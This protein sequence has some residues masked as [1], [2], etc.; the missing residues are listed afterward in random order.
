MNRFLFILLVICS[1]ASGQDINH[2]SFNDLYD[3]NVTTVFDINERDDHTMW[4]GTSEGLV[5]FD[6]VEFKTFVNEDYAIAYTNIKFDEAGRVWCSNFGGQ[7]FYLE[8]DSLQLGVNWQ[9]QGDFIRDY[10]VNQLPDMQVVG[11]NTGEILVFNVTDASKSKSVFK[12]DRSKILSMSVRDEMRYA[13]FKEDKAVNQGSLDLYELGELPAENSVV[14]S[15]SINLPPGKWNIF[16]NEENLLMYHFDKVGNLYKL[17]DDTIQPILE[18]IELST[19]RLNGV[20]LI[21]DRIWVLSKKG[22]SIY[23]KDGEEYITGSFDGTSVS[24]VFKDHEGNIWLGSLNRGIYVIPN[25]EFTSTLLS[26][27][28]IAHSTFDE[29]G[30]LFVLDDE[31][32]LYYVPYGPKKYS[33]IQLITKNLEP[34]PLFYDDQAKKLFIGNLGTYFDCANKR[35]VKENGN[36]HKRMRFKE[37]VKLKND[38]YVFTNYSY[39]GLINGTEDKSQFNFDLVKDYNIRRFRSKHIGISG[40]KDH[41]YIDYI[42]GLFYYSK[43]NVPKRLKRRGAD[44]QSSRIV[45]DPINNEIVWVATKTK[46]LLKFDKGK[47]VKSIKLPDVANRISIHKD[48]IFLAGQQAIM[49]YDRKSEDIDFIDETDGWMKGRVTSMACKDSLCLI[50]GSNFL[51]KFPVYYSTVN[52]VVPE[53]YITSINEKKY[54]SIKEN[55]LIFPPGKNYIT[56][57]FRGLSVRSQKKLNYQYRLS[58]K[59]NEWIE[60]S[61]DRPEALFL[62][63]EAGSYTFEV[64]ACNESGVCSEP[65]TLQFTIEE[66]YYKKWWF[67]GVVFLT[68]GLIIFFTLRERFKTKEKQERLKS[69]QQR[70]RKEAYKSKIAAI[71]SQM[72][73]HFMFNALNTIQEFILTNQQEIASEYLADF[74]DLMRIYLDQSREDNVSISTEVETLELYLR[75]EN[76]RFNGDLTYEVKVDPLINKDGTTIPV[77]LLQP[78]VENSIKHGLLHKK[79]D[80]RLVISF[81]R[82]DN[83]GIKCVVEDNGIGRTSS[84]KINKSKSIGHKSFATGANQSRVELINQNRDKKLKVNI[85]DLYKD[86]GP[87]GTRVEIYI[88]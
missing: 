57:S 77:M 80:K 17:K 50:V 25:I 79:D 4:F 35:L 9:N 3:F 47:V 59:S 22:L 7:L 52:Q 36:R 43:T 49:R 81:A 19:Y 72:N 27:N 74:A 18:N 67:I 73:P 83:G 15:F 20:D 14:H 87:S 37:A 60:A 5:S 2:F 70:L 71:R 62:N 39:A 11:S 8:D 24:S 85:I 34:S 56:L 44:I 21:E 45:P 78:Y 31:G 69:E 66:P 6:G 58:N 51:Q 68:I 82:L 30:N 84:S 23:D 38:A 32:N 13:V 16:G 65:K 75:L 28:S 42:D 26:D 64:R 40:D 48:Y 54:D 46:E 10:A 61:F 12:K 86:G 53:V 55:D 63:L 1:S 76:L 41:L 88:N 33:D 29:A